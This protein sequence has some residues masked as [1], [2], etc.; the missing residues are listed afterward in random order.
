[1]IAQALPS[2]IE[3]SPTEMGIGSPDPGLGQINRHLTV[4]NQTRFL[5]LSVS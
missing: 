2:G 4:L 5:L 3:I 1:M